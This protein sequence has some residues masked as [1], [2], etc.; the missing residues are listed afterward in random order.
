MIGGYNLIRSVHSS[1]TKRVGVSIYYKES[2]AVRIVNITLTESL[3]CEV[4]IQ[5]KKRYVA[6]VYR[7]PRSPI[8]YH[9][10]RP[11]FQIARVIVQGHCYLT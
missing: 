7:A 1:N 10:R 9:V 2:V 8:Q 6:V 3:V 5:N 11:Q 4:P